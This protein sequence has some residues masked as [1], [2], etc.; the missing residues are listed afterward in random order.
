V[1]YS[2]SPRLG[3]DLGT[4]YVSAQLTD[5]AGGKTSLSGLT[6]VL[7]RGAYQL[8][9]DVAVLTVSI[10]LPTGQKTISSSQALLA[11]GLSTD[12]VPFPVMN[13]GTGFSVTTG[14]ALAQPV[15]PWALG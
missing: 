10:N 2:F 8:K 5:S 3:V 6:D 11:N 4:Y 9:P 7:L 1:A 13:F 15:G 12:L 14:I